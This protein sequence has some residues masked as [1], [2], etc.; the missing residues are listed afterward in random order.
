MPVPI[1]DLVWLELQLVNADGIVL[2]HQFV[3]RFF[4]QCLYG[5]LMGPLFFLS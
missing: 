2:E 5:R 1:G 3:V 4:S